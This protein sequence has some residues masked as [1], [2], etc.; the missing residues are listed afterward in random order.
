MPALTKIQSALTFIK[1]IRYDGKDENPARPLI[2]HQNPQLN[3][4]GV[5]PAPPLPPP[6]RVLYQKINQGPEEQEPNGEA[7]HQP[8]KLTRFGY[9]RA[10]KKLEDGNKKALENVPATNPPPREEPPENYNRLIVVDAGVGC[11]QPDQTTALVVCQPQTDLTL[12]AAKFINH[13]N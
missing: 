1:T 4:L 11:K 8:A 12:A 2:R 3:D 10:V 5:A 6:R 9:I 13:P 7:R